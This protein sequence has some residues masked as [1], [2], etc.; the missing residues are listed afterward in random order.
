MSRA[1]DAPTA[2]VTPADLAL[3]QYTSGSTG[4]PKGVCLTHD[5]L[6][7]NCEAIMRNMGPDP[8]RVIMS[9]LPPY[10][11]MGL[12]GTHPADLLLRLVAG[13]DVADALRSRASAAG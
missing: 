5:N 1:V 2:S 12:M 3:I 8:D 10:H 6:V 13:A 11:D 4:T 7:S 9:W